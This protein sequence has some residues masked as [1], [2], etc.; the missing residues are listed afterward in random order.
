MLLPQPLVEQPTRPVGLFTTK[1][2]ELAIDSCRKEVES[3]AKSCRAKN[4]RF[5]DYDFDL[6]YDAFVCLNG[7]QYAASVASCSGYSSQRVT[8]IFEEPQFFPKGGAIT[9]NGIT[10]GSLGDC[11]FLAALATVSSMPG[12]I[13]KIC[14]ARDEAV[15]V[16]GF[17]FYG[18]DGWKSVII[19]DLLLTGSSKF[20][21]LDVESKALYHHDKE[22]YE[23]IARKGGGVLLFAK[24]G[25]QNEIW[26]PLIEKAF[27]KHY[28]NYA[29]IVG[30]FTNE[31]VED[32]TG[33][34]S[35]TFV[36]KDILDHDRFWQ[37]ELLKVNKDRLFG[38]CF[39][40][41]NGADATPANVE[42]LVG[43]HAYSLLRAVE[44]KGKR[45]LILRNPWGTGEWTGRWSDG[46]KEWTPEWVAALPELGHC[47]GDD[48]QFVIEYPD[49]LKCFDRI[50]RTLLFD[51]TWAA[52]S[53][54]VKVDLGPEIKA[55]GYGQ[56]SFTVVLP[57]KSH[58]IFSF[59]R[60]NQRFFQS[61]MKSSVV[62][63][64]FAV[65]RKGEREPLAT[66]NEWHPFSSRSVILE[67]NLEP[68]TYLVYVRFERES[69]AYQFSAN[70]QN[71]SNR[72][73]T[74][75]VTQ[76]VCAQSVVKG[77]KSN[78]QKTFI[79][80]PLKDVIE[81]DIKKE[82][83]AQLEEKVKLDETEAIQVNG[84]N[85]NI[86]GGEGNNNGTGTAIEE[87]LQWTDLLQ[88]T[89]NAIFVRLRIYT[90]TKEPATII[91]SR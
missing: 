78:L 28:G 8:E 52:A 13:E 86:N 51:N 73:N 84:N 10:Q 61:I 35:I 31:A 75:I 65:V 9:S 34:A 71:L 22:Q 87:N 72:V 50:E 25:S 67:L 81:D 43:S 91:G 42:G 20:E 80:R 58:T 57:E 6:L 59:S 7:F 90:Q 89:G 26:V 64:T 16:Y 45:F 62:S 2:L 70:G 37:Q 39:Q 27:A 17:I 36:V 1:D 88:E 54:W 21:E 23:A 76:R 14:V 3:I 83:E 77:W 41:L 30:G 69:G 48:G 60:L 46:S 53:S 74:R 79:P 32:L 24:A 11:W 4:V 18:D 15:G 82:K 38:C 56:L 33:G 85:Q 19:D 63:L 44:C 49:F 47:F 29:H 55:W 5:R 40:A 68:G 66:A 12:L